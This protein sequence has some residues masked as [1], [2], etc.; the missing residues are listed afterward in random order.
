M[1]AHA[2]SSH[3]AKISPDIGGRS[4]NQR[5]EITP[6][7]YFAKQRQFVF[8]YAFIFVYAF[9]S[10]NTSDSR[11]E[12]VLNRNRISGLGWVLPDIGFVFVYTNGF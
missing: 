1:T 8:V 6:R 9:T 10:T 2:N 5:Y 12:I 3:N 4:A 11:A 7:Y